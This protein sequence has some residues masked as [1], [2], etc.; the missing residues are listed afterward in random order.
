MGRENERRRDLERIDVSRSEHALAHR[1]GILRHR[2]AAPTDCPAWDRSGRDMVTETMSWL[3]VGGF[4]LVGGCGLPAAFPCD[5]DADCVD[6][7]RFGICQPDGWCSFPDDGCGS[8]QRYGAHAGGGLAGLCVDQPDTSGAT[9]GETGAALSEGP[10]VTTLDATGPIDGGGDTS[11][12]GFDETTSSAS[13]VTSPST[14]NT[15]TLEGPPSDS[16]GSEGTTET[17]GNG[18]IDDGEECDGADLG[19][20][21]CASLDAGVG[22]LVCDGSCKY[23]FSMCEDDVDFDDYGP[24]TLATDCE[25]MICHVF[26]GNGTCLPA[27]MSGRDCPLLM[28]ALDPVCSIDGFCLIPC[29]IE[30]DCPEP[31]RCDDSVYGLVCLW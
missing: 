13:A 10:S 11:T 26:A 5:V 4:V 17:C 21:D 9:D 18:M 16:G 2:A 27:C 25:A 6:G 3:R 24:C 1:I 14:G 20:Q 29:T 31:M 12:S 19:E 8:G 28:G 30:E 7:G 23:D 22:L 15:S